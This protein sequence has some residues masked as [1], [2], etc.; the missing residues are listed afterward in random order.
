MIDQTYEAEIRHI[1][2]E[3][4]A[5]LGGHLLSEYGTKPIT[6]PASEQT[7]DNPQLASLGGYLLEHYGQKPVGAGE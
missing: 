1:V 3:E 2:R 7:Q 6:E 5:A 4:L